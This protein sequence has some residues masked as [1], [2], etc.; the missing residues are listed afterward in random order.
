M[1][2]LQLFE[3]IYLQL[4]PVEAARKKIL[5]ELIK[6]FSLPN[7]DSKS[8]GVL[9]EMFFQYSQMQNALME[10]FQNKSNKQIAC[11]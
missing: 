6:V 2:T 7:I 1:K 4:Y 5:F 8:L 11:W 3:N 9:S 10:I